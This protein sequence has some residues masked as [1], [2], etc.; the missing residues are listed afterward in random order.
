MPWWLT[1]L[2]GGPCPTIWFNYGTA[3][4]RRWADP[5]LQ[6]R[7]GFDLKLPAGTQQGVTLTLAAHAKGP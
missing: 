3:G 7:Y 5:G 6:R 2:H 1:D 4:N